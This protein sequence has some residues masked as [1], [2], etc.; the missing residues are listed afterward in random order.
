MTR[1][2]SH[3]NRR[4]NRHD[5]WKKMCISVFFPEITCFQKKKTVCLIFFGW[6]MKNVKISAI[7]LSGQVLRIRRMWLSHHH[8]PETKWP[9]KQ[10]GKRFATESIT[11]SVSMWAQFHEMTRSLLNQMTSTDATE[12]PVELKSA[13]PSLFSYPEKTHWFPT[14]P[15]TNIRISPSPLLPHWP[16]R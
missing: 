13:W 10:S 3:P 2:A 14:A 1:A 4:T 15:C 16:T 9:N 7:Y 5:M 11:I 12:T 6:E 8:S